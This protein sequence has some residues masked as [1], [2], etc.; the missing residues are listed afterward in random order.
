M[1][2][3]RV[4]A[5]ALVFLA[6]SAAF[7]GGFERPR[8][9]TPRVPLKAD[10]IGQAFQLPPEKVVEAVKRAGPRVTAADVAAKG[11]LSLQEARKGVVELAAALGEDA[12]LQVSKEG[13]IVYRFPSNVQVALSKASSAAAVREAWNAAK[14][15]VLTG[16]RCM[17]GVALFAS[18]AVIYAAIIAISTSS[19]DRDRDDRRRG[20]SFGG[21]GFDMSFGPRLYY[22]S[23]PFDVLFYRPYTAPYRHWGDEY[24]P[25]PPEMGFLE[26]VYSFVFGDGDPN[27]GREEQQLAAVAAWARR[28]DGVLTAEQLAPLLD[29][30]EYPSGSSYNVNESWALPALQRLN[31]RPEVAKSGQIV[32]VFDDLQTTAGQYERLRRSNPPAI[33]EEREIPFSLADQG[34]LVLVGLLGAA[35]LIGAAYLGAEF[36]SLDAGVKLIGFLGTVKAL[37]PALV[38]YAVSFF[39]VPALRFLSLKKRNSDIDERNK[40]RRQW[41]DVLRS[42]EVDGKLAEARKYKQQMREISSENSVYSTAKEAAPQSADQDLEDFDRRLRS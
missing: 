8:A 19:S 40:H 20:D 25:E 36:A 22:G 17:F 29:P 37:Y 1:A 26:S 6:L 28:N 16:L 15:T 34:S 12:E 2:R 18:I 31:G 11:G 5:V 24:E 27:T 30:P 10:A 41:L 33:L 4:L 9:K 3:V 14:P 7:T 21:G 32:Y 13:E 39:A 35:N 23:S 42:G 38:G